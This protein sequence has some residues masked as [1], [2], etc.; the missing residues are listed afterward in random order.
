MLSIKQNLQLSIKLNHT[1]GAN[2]TL[3]HLLFFWCFFGFVFFLGG[4]EGGLLFL[5]LR[6]S[7]LHYRLMRGSLNYVVKRFCRV[8][9]K[10]ETLRGTYRLGQDPCQHLKTRNT[11]QKRL[12]S[13]KRYT[14]GFREYELAVFKSHERTARIKMFL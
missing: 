9:I 6:F 4:G 8:Q 10:T 3:Y 11:Q 5:L 7:C 1:V 12:T 14:R 13:F 2:L